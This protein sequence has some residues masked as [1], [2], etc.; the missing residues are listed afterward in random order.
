MRRFI[1]TTRPAHYECAALPTELHQRIKLW[2]FCKATFLISGLMR[3]FIVTPWPAHYECAALPTELHQ[4]IKLLKNVRLR[5]DFQ[6]CR[7]ITTP[8]PAHYECAALPT[9]LHQHIKLWNFVK[10]MFWS[11]RYV[12]LSVVCDLRITNALLYRL[13]EFALYERLVRAFGEFAAASCS[14]YTSILNCENL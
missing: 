12:A 7:F 4:H 11:D 14:C 9:E 6:L 8:R 1:T 13:V 10:S 3:R 2:K 5:F